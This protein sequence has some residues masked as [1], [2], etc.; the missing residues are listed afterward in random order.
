[1]SYIIINFCVT[2]EKKRWRENE[3]KDT[4]IGNSLFQEQKSVLL[5]TTSTFEGTVESLQK[6][7]RYFLWQVGTEEYFLSHIMA[8]RDFWR[9]SLQLWSYVIVVLVKLHLCSGE[10]N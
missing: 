2:M 8:E 9:N 7:G 4:M 5:E 3:C 1:M 6:K 10:R